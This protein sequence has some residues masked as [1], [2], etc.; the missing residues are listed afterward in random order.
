MPTAIHGTE[1]EEHEEYAMPSRA[2]DYWEAVT[3][4]PCPVPGCDQTVIWY[5]A[6]YVPGYRACARRE[7]KGFATG[8]IRHKFLAS[9]TALSPTLVRDECCE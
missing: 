7:V 5:E 8:S 9:G 3:N 6:G 2:P 1:D 4:V